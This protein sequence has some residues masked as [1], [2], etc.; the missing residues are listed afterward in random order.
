M[1]GLES[2]ITVPTLDQ[3]KARAF[4]L[5]HVALYALANPPPAV[6]AEVFARW[7]E[8]ERMA[9]LRQAEVDREAFWALLGPLRA[10]LSPREQQFAGANMTTMTQ[11]QRVAAAWRTEALQTLLWALGMVSAMA[12]YDTP[13]GDAPIQ[14]YSAAAFDSALASAKLRPHAEL[15]AARGI[16]ETWLWRARTRQVINAGTPLPQSP[17]LLQAGIKTY[18]DIVRATAKMAAKRGTIPEI[19]DDDFPIFGTAYRVATEKEYHLARSIATERLF[20][21]NWLCGRA[22]EGRWDETPTDT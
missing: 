2:N 4:V 14:A 19:I 3:A 1:P 17:Q 12:P 16:A 11:A 9:A 7:T 22:P 21:L 13:A 20:V 6:S 5:R 15:A 10:Q 18:D 8:E